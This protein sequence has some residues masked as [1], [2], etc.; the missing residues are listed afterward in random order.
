MVHAVAAEEASRIVA[1]EISPA[2]FK[3]ELF[4][5]DG[6]SLEGSD[7]ITSGNLLV[8]RRR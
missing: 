3:I 5:E 8:T 1:G 7:G 4:R 2:N 6:R